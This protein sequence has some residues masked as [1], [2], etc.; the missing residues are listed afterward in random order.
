MHSLPKFFKKEMSENNN[1]CFSYQYKPFHFQNKNFIGHLEPATKENATRQ[2]HKIIQYFMKILS[3]SKIHLISVDGDF[4]YDPAFKRQL[5]R[6][7]TLY[8]ENNLLNFFNHLF[9]LGPI[10]DSDFFIFGQKNI[11]KMKN[12]HN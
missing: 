7:L 4:H 6:L 2:I 3:K 1:C 10:M 11:R 8:D 12:T 9:N 5:N